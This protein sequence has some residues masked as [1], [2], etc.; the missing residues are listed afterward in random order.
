MTGIMMLDTPY[1]P[2][3]NTEAKTTPSST[4]KLFQSINDSESSSTLTDVS[5]NHYGRRIATCSSDNIVRVYDYADNEEWVSNYELQISGIHKGYA[6]RVCWCHPEYGQILATCSEFDN[7]VCIWQEKGGLTT[8]INTSS[9]DKN[10]ILADATLPMYCVQFA[11]Y[12]LGLKLA[13]GSADGVVRIYE[14][15][16]L[17]DTKNWALQSTI[18][19]KNL[20][21]KVGITC[22]S[23][24]STQFEPPTLVIGTSNGKTLVY[25][26][27]DS[28]HHWFMV[29]SL[30]SK[31]GIS[32]VSWSTKLG[33]DHHTIASITDNGILS[34]YRIKPD[35]NGNNPFAL[36]VESNQVLDEG[37][38]G[39]I[40]SG[41]KRCGWNTIGT[42]LAS[43]SDNNGVQLWNESLS[44]EWKCV[45]KVYDNYMDYQF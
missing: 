37:G 40:S 42:I 12:H 34:V 9:W 25:R 20:N 24:C 33:K 29:L 4:R 7:T 32:D 31:S 13:T 27:N 45:S 26:Y 3:S 28:S 30:S 43:S 39:D 8:S 23:W 17:R 1:K 11:P 18:N 36:F 22:L 6:T 19:V 5:Y 44:H 15:C 35:K 14:A 10:A 38:V 41:R 16:S 21:E 2:K